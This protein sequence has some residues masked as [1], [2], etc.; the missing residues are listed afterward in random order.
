MAPWPALRQRLVSADAARVS[1]LGGNPLPGSGFG[2]R[3]C[4]ASFR[5]EAVVRHHLFAS[6]QPHEDRVRIECNVSIGGVHLRIVGHV[7]ALWVVEAWPEPSCAP[8]S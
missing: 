3:L 2:S 6:K 4:T 7:F 1:R 8:S 5:L